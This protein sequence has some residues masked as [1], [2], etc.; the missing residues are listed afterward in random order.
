M[1]PRQWRRYIDDDGESQ[2]FRVFITHGRSALRKKI[3]AFIEDKLRFA[4]DTLV[5]RFTGS[6]IIDKLKDA[7]WD[8]DCGV[9]IMTPDD[10]QMPSKSF[11]ARQN[12][13]HEIGYLQGLFADKELVLILK[14]ESVEWFSNVNGIEYIEFKGQGISVAFPKL[15]QALEEI[16]E[17]Y[18]DD[19]E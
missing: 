12:V 6:V 16:Y 19:S 13:I 7:A 14:E 11:R 10:Q 15:K 3:K 17:Y 4:T 2:V 8:C 1:P 5:D 18:R 9:V